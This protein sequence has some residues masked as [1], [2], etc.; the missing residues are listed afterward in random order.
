MKDYEP[1]ARRMFTPLA[2]TYDLKFAALDGDEFFLI[3]QGFALWIFIDLR[4]MRSD[5]WYVSVDNNGIVLT[6]TMMYIQKERFDY[7]NSDVFGKP[8]TFDERIEANLRV[9]SYWLMNKFQDILMGDKS[10]LQGYPDNGDYSRHVTK[11]LAPYFRAQ[12]YPVI[13]REDK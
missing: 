11:F 13:V 7:Q 12:G 8:T 3:G 10:W 6:Y 1:I 4:D 5:F 2:Q 9:D